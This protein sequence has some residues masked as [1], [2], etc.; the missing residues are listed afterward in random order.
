[1][2]LASDG[3]GGVLVSWP[4]LAPTSGAGTRYQLARGELDVAWSLGLVPSATCAGEDVA[5]SSWRDAGAGSAWYLARARNACGRGPWGT[6][7]TP[8]ALDAFEPCP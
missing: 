2:V 5:T 7:D 1:V 6:E 4:D 8:S 3:S